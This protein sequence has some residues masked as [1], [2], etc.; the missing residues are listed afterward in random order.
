M[1]YEVKV[2]D[3]GGNLLRVVPREDLEKRAIERARSLITN[4]DRHNILRFED[5]AQVSESHSQY[6]I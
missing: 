6:I 1:L 5:Q 3:R 4:R 2:F